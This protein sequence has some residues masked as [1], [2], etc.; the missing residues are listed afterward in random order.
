MATINKACT[1]Y[2]IKGLKGLKGPGALCKIGQQPFCFFDAIAE[3]YFEDKR[4][5]IDQIKTNPSKF[6]ILRGPM[7]CVR[8]VH[9]AFTIDGGKRSDRE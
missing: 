1:K 7:C 2:Y 3:S 4:G 9:N 5:F 8:L 6:L